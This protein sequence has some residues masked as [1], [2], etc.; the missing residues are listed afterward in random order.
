MQNP[1][2]ALA[3]SLVAFGGLAVASASVGLAL[4]GIP[5]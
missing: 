4:V 1:V 2:H 3:L 5:H